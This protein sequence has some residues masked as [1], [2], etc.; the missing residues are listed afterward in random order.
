M[1][2][3]TDCKELT[4][5]K[6]PVKSKLHLD[7]DLFLGCDKLQTVEN[8]PG[9][10]NYFEG[11][12]V[13]TISKNTFRDLTELANITLS[14]NIERI[15]DGAFANCRSLR[16]I[17]LPES[18]KTI[19]DEA[20]YG[21]SL[22]RIVIPA[23]VKSI[24]NKA[25]LENFSD[26]DDIKE[27][28]PLKVVECLGETPAT[29]GKAVFAA[30]GMNALVV[31]DGSE[32]AYEAAQ[33]WSSM[34]GKM[35]LKA[36]IDF[37]TKYNYSIHYSSDYSSAT[38]TLTSCDNKNV[39]S[40]VIPNYIG[41][42]DDIRWNDALIPVT[43]IADNALADCTDLQT[44]HITPN[45][46]DDVTLTLG[47]NAFPSGFKAVVLE[48]FEVER[49]KKT[50]GWKD[51]ADKII[52]DYWKQ[53]VRDDAEAYYY[54]K[55][56]PVAFLD[57]LIPYDDN[58]EE[59][60]AESRTYSDIEFD[61]LAEITPTTGF[62]VPVT[63][64]QPCAFD[65]FSNVTKLTIPET[66]ET[67]KYNALRGLS[68]LK[69]LHLP[70]GLKEIGYGCFDE[71]EQLTVYCNGNP[72]TIISQEG[73][74]ALTA[75]LSDCPELYPIVMVPEDKLSAYKSVNGSLPWGNLRC[76]TTVNSVKTYEM[77]DATKLDNAENSVPDG[78]YPT[79]SLTYK[80]VFSTPEQYAT[81]SLPFDISPADYT[82]KIDIYL[83]VDFK[84]ASS[85]NYP[86]TGLAIRTGNNVLLSLEKVSENYSNTIAPCTPFLVKAKEG[87]SEV[88]FHTVR[89]YSVDNSHSWITKQGG[90][91]NVY[92]WDRTSGLMTKADDFVLLA[93]GTCVDIPA[94]SHEAGMADLYTFNSDGTFGIADNVPAFRMYLSTAK[95]SAQSAPLRIAISIDGETTDISGITETLGSS[96]SH[97]PV[98]S[99]DGKMVSADGST[100]HLA[101]GIYIKNG[102]KFVVKK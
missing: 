89:P 37:S 2:T 25:F 99:I 19:G 66:V 73:Y 49:Y 100:S 51:I 81:V 53:K 32:A 70:N 43:A 9:N 34:K 4:E 14:D 79:G 84:L 44:L 85:Q 41:I 36:Y 45:Y 40:V 21:T 87:V 13:H 88:T 98:Y 57:A 7:N 75:N 69:E 62:N 28:Y 26:Y 95:Q 10:M 15:D 90:R 82:D 31:P 65:L 22:S 74:P 91:L 46:S 78:F 77:T 8:Y 64:I 35:A 93:S 39:R 71:C 24:G 6:F 86:A 1:C 61:I 18:L 60:D 50:D 59:N 3:F 63:G 12:D 56:G 94:E 55:P 58:E 83:L 68:K 27:K 33:G 76:I 47:S 38:A 48:E 20:F 67:I 54:I 72:A 96:V 97:S 17:T 52:P 42:N 101:K 11:E 102:K 23:N 5:V 30:A 92:D 16:S 29:L 80:R